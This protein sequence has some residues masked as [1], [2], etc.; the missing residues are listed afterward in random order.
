MQSPA[1]SACARCPAVLGRSC[2]EAE[3]GEWLA[4]LTCADVTRIGQALQ[5]SARVFCDEE[6]LSLEEARAYELHRPLFAG[7][8]RQG[9][10][11]LTLKT[12]K[13]ACVLL[14]RATGCVL[15]ESSR[16]TACRLYPFE[17]WPDGSFSV[18]ATGELRCLAV[19]ESSGVEALQAAL[20][21]SPEKLA[22]LAGQLRE[23]VQAHSRV[24]P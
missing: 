20:G 7:Y 12:A 10:K 4:T 15:P 11:R 13:G 6:W 8:F 2:C 9:P 19:D 17:P 21:Q 14:D 22:A 18:L 16:P 1:K 24:R 23:E 3:P 5:R